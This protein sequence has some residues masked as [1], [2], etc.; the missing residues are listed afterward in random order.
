M[1]AAFWTAASLLMPLLPVYTAAAQ[2]EPSRVILVGSAESRSRPDN[3]IR[4][5]PARRQTSG[6]AWLDRKQVLAHGFTIKFQFQLTSQGGLNRGADGL[7]FVI[8]NQGP[9]ALAGR[10]SA[11]GFALGD[12][13]EDRNSPGIPH[14]VAVFFDTHRNGE[15]GDPS[16][17][18]VALCTNGP[19]GAMKWPPARLAVANRLGKIRLK[20]GK[21]HDVRIVYQP[22][23]LAAYLDQMP[24]PLFR[25]PVDLRQ[26]LDSEGAAYIGFTA[27][28]GNGFQN[29][30][31]LS[32]TFTLDPRTD[33]TSTMTSVRSEIQ[34]ERGDCL[35]GLNL[36]T[37]RDAIVERLSEG[38]YSVLL[39]AHLPWGA[40]TG[41][42]Q[43]QPVEITNAR[44]VVCFDV[45]GDGELECAGPQGLATTAAAGAGFV[46]P[47]KPPG[48]LLVDTRGGRTRLSVNVPLHGK[49]N[50]GYF[51]FTVT[52]R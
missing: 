8:Q 44:G 3:R 41:N 12:G 15:A 51:E 45:R 7:A 33:V 30:D 43:S 10:G 50:Q 42:P 39:P 6:A 36:C 48:A 49:R 11:G 4:L 26:V 23:M 38:V 47:S 20:D 2:A 5:T 25:V 9:G 1:T 29:H 21:P 52:R 37:P 27:A 19:L 24:G 14:S 13:Q 16:D 17:N 22:P 34:F 32:W 46:D 35:P 28:T 40:A 31:I 18:Y